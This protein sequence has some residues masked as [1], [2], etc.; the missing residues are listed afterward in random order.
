M[1]ASQPVPLNWK[2]KYDLP[3]ALL[4]LSWRGVSDCSGV[5]RNLHGLVRGLLKVHKNENF[6]GSDFELCIL[7]LLVML[8][9]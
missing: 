3:Y 5:Q 1:V 9:Y 2:Y 8:K 4:G 7:S 6:F